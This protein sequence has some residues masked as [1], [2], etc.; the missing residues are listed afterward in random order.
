M[1]HIFRAEWDVTPEGIDMRLSELRAEAE[2]GPLQ[3]L[4]FEH[5]AELVGDLKWRIDI[6]ARPWRLVAEGPA[7]P[8][9]DERGKKAA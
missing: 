2:A 5:C 4:L 3:D 8:W 9:Q 1:G 6:R 7:R